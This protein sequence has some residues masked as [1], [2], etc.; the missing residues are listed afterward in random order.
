MP[1][2]TD[3][4]GDDYIEE[5]LLCMEDLLVETLK[6]I[7]KQLS[8]SMF[9]SKEGWDAPLHDFAHRGLLDELITK[10]VKRV[11]GSK[12]S[13]LYQLLTHFPNFAKKTLQRMLYAVPW[14]LLQHVNWRYGWMDPTSRRS[15]N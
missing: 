5:V 2:S 12:E 8:G 10:L 13:P 6:K 7:A 9:D 15:P 1:H 4:C 3:H 11:D 14:S